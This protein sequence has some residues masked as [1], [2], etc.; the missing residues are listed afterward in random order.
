MLRAPLLSAFVLAFGLLPHGPCLAAE[1]AAQIKSGDSVVT[2]V[3]ARVARAAKSKIA[4]TYLNPGTELTAK[5]ITDNWVE[6]AV[7]QAGQP[8]KGW[9]EI[10]QL[11][12]AGPPRAKHPYELAMRSLPAYRIAPPDVLSIEMLKLIP[13]PPYRAGIFDVLQIKA[14]ALPDQPIDNYFIVEAEGSINLGPTYGSVRV[15]GMTIDEI[16][17]ALNKWIGQWL[18]EPTVSV[19]LSRVSGAQPVT[20]QYLV[21][22]DG[23][24]NLRK[25]GSLHVAGKTVAEARLAL[26]KLLAATLNAPELSVDVAEYRS[27]VYYVIIEA[28]GLEN[29]VLPLARYGQRD[30]AGCGKP[31]R[32]SSASGQQEDLDCSR[33]P[34]G[35]GGNRIAGRLGSDCSLCATA[36][37]YQVLPGDRLVIAD[38]MPK[39]VE[40][41]RERGDARELN[42]YET[43]WQAWPG[44]RRADKVFPISLG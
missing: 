10:D 37:N 33:C 9:I 6:V 30:R 16:K 43:V 35:G 7:V 13:R 17:A 3:R 15:A 22:P 44:E 38:E 29:R 40:H 8:A 27:H 32:Q 18:R 14:N 1:S 34:A 12:K 19:Q 5:D 28:S 20:G 31:D 11:A 2:R 42:H 41:S 23:T 39:S 24:I 25:Y 36:S 4:L 26:Q 21:G